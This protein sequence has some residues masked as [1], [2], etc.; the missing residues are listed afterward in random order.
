MER[1]VGQNDE[2]SC[3]PCLEIRIESNYN[4]SHLKIWARMMCDSIKA[5]QRSVWPLHSEGVLV[6]R[7]ERTSIRR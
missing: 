6:D 3:E 2:V 4:E 5:L 7:T 1:Q